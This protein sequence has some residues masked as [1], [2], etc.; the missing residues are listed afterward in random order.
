MEL[1]GK[2]LAIL[3]HIYGETH[4][5]VA[6]SYLH[7]ADALLQIHLLS[8]R[9]HNDTSAQRRAGHASAQRRGSE[10]GAGSGGV[11]V[12]VDE[13]ERESGIV[14]CLELYTKGLAIKQELA[15]AAAM[16]A[17]VSAAAA[18]GG[19]ATSSGN[20]RRAAAYV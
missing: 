2:G 9:T 13:R 10:G 12:S 5:A 3:S 7:Q 1:I 17:A 16:A 6:A 20:A 18:E 4:P 14:R 8:H 11:V 15:D 19:A